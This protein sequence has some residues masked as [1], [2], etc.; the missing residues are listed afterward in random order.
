MS[1]YRI[2]LTKKQVQMLN[3]AV[4]FTNVNHVFMAGSFGMDARDYKDEVDTLVSIVE[5]KAIHSV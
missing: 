4:R 2:S 1:K 5:K 3:E